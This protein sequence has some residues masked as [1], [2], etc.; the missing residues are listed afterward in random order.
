[1]VCS[2]PSGMV[3]SSALGSSPPTHDAKR[4]FGLA[5]QGFLPSMLSLVQASES[6]LPIPR[7]GSSI[8]L[9]LGCLLPA[10]RNTS[11]TIKQQRCEQPP[12]PLP[13]PVH[14]STKHQHPQQQRQQQGVQSQ[15]DAAAP[16]S[17]LGNAVTSTPST[18]TID[19]HQHHSHQQQQVVSSTAVL[20]PRRGSSGGITAKE[21][22]GAWA[23][24]PHNPERMDSLRQELGEGEGVTALLEKIKSG[25]N[26]YILAT[27]DD[28]VMSDDDG[29]PM[30]PTQRLRHDTY[31]ASV[32][33]MDALCDASSSLTSYSQV[34]VCG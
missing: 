3:M 1:M 13:P 22:Q 11:F 4:G 16:A 9:D 26:G 5:S 21:F 2:P 7:R 27:E 15:A 34:S 12:L 23:A 30:S 17:K 29:G 25:G 32:D 14:I 31:G 6:A 10:E 24:N 28:G 8:A 20:A 33:F 19:S 18:A